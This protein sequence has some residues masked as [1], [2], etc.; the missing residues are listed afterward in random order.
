MPAWGAHGREDEVWSVV[1]FLLTLPTINVADYRDLAFGKVHLRDRAATE[2]TQIG[3]DPAAFTACARC[4]GD[5][6]TQPQ[7]R[8]VPQLAG[9][10]AAYLQTALLDYAGRQRQSGIMQPVA[11]ELDAGE[12]QRL[13][14]HY[15]R[16][17]A[18]ASPKPQISAEQLRRGQLLATAGM[19]ENGIP[20]CITCH[21]G[22][23]RPTYPKLAG[24]FSSYIIG[25]L[26][27]FQEGTRDQTSQA[28][29]MTMIARRLSA[30]Q[31]QDV[32]LFFEQLEPR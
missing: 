30:Q 16:L 26:K 21:G 32:A 9:Q 15:S 12:V 31:A 2:I 20:P 4:H 13:S 17:A 25:Q 23:G 3:S 14:L 5:H 8:L 1:A 27:L 7:S 28:K 6:E 24:Q 19:P 22:T 10:S 11:A 29:I 18:A